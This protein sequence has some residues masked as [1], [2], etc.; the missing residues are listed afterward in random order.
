M[1]V[2]FSETVSTAGQSS[3]TVKGDIL[4]HNGTVPARLAVGS[5]GSLLATGSVAGAYWTSLS[6]SASGYEL[7]ATTTVTTAI[8]SVTFSSIS[9]SYKALVLRGIARTHGGESAFI[10]IGTTTNTA[11]LYDSLTHTSKYTDSTSKT[12][13]RNNDTSI[14]FMIRGSANSAARANLF[15]SFTLLITQPNATATNSSNRTFLWNAVGYDGARGATDND[16]HWESGGGGPNSAVAH[17]DVVN[18]LKIQA[19][20]NSHDVGSRFSLYGLK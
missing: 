16:V 9:S 5:N 17:T 20:S 19:E 13:E 11:I 15:G 6:V 12:F 14:G 8:S 1:S 7:I 3:L 18:Y 4:V 10:K 2:S